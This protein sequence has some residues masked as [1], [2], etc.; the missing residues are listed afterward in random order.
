MSSQYS[1]SGKTLVEIQEIKDQA[2]QPTIIGKWAGHEVKELHASINKIESFSKRAAIAFVVAI[3]LTAIIAY[4]TGNG[5]LSQKTLSLFISGGLTVGVM[6]VPLLA[7]YTLYKCQ[8]IYA[9][10]HQ[11]T[12]KE[13][14][15]M[16]D[17]IENLTSA[18]NT[19]KTEQQLQKLGVEKE[20]FKKN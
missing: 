6:G 9:Q 18:A 20:Y 14:D 17:K 2:D 8:L 1:I 12:D 16:Y 19:N 5:S 13:I 7:L 4:T 3:A 11:L 10:K 15:R